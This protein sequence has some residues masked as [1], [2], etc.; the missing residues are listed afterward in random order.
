MIADKWPNGPLHD[1]AELEQSK[2][3]MGILNCQKEIYSLLSK[4]LSKRVDF[5]GIWGQALNYQFL[6][7]S[8][9]RRPPPEASM[10]RDALKLFN[11]H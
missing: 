5:Q 8:P 2:Y 11:W 6:S 10:K 7:S 9:G 4:L 1:P 3:K